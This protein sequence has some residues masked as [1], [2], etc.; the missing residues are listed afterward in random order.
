MIHGS[1]I[2]CSFLFFLCFVCRTFNAYANVMS[3]PFLFLF[4]FFFFF[5]WYGSEVVTPIASQSFLS[6]CCFGFCFLFCFSCRLCGF[7]CN[8]CCFFFLC[9]FLACLCFVLHMFIFAPTQ[10]IRFLLT[11]MNMSSCLLIC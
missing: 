7:H 8:N 5:D 1:H 9:L 4:F 10:S 6:S 11:V 2:G 3:Y